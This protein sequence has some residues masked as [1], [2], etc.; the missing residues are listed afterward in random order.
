MSIVSKYC[1]LILIDKRKVFDWERLIINNMSLRFTSLIFFLLLS[2]FIYIYSGNHL[3][4]QRRLW[5]YCWG[6][7]LI[8]SSILQ[9]HN[10]LYVVCLALK[11][12]YGKFKLWKQCG[13]IMF[14][15]FLISVNILIMN[16]IHGHDDIALRLQLD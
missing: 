7:W 12:L 3:L 11:W 9:V 5:R 10:L 16:L 15:V 2:F 14:D 1:A 13:D 8:E 6:L 4:F